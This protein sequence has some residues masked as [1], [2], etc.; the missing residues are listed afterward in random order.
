MGT[1][2]FAA[3]ILE[4]LIVAQYQIVGVVSQPDR[5]V[6][7]N[8]IVEP[9]PTK[10]LALK[11]DIPIF[12]VQKIRTDYFFME[13]LKPDMI[14][15]CAYGQIL[16]KALLSIPVQGCINV[17]ASLLPKFRGGAPIHHSII[18]G[19]TKTGVSIMKMSE[20]MDAGDVYAQAEIP[21]E[22]NDNVGVLFQKLATLGAR[23][24]I[25]ILPEIL[26]HTLL[27]TPQNEAEVTYA[28]T[29]KREEEKISWNRSSREVFN[30]IRGLSPI[31]GAYTTL[32]K[33]IIKVFHCAP[34]EW[35]G[36]Q[37]AGSIIL[38]DDHLYVKTSDAAVSL[39][40]V[41]Q[42]GKKRMTIKEFLKGQTFLRSG[43]K[44]D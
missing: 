35:N 40:E 30:L 27:P 9:T 4:A 25:K 33:V 20:K 42:A 36:L 3:A 15:T 12:Q 21:I 37:E 10:K 14:I 8:K 7:R 1:P 22:E 17:H 24:L 16:P 31:P 11:Y 19:H 13:E 5:P 41:Q 23:L 38:G 43:M 29:I 44:F 34:I 28:P 39:L 6:G 26:N 32:D 18:Q 2:D